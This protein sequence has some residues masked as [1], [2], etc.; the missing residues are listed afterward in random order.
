M[1]K[2]IKASSKIAV[3]II[4]S[5]DSIRLENLLS[6]IHKREACIPF[7]ILGR[8]RISD[9][10]SSQLTSSITAFLDRNLSYQSLLDALHKSKLFYNHH[11]RLRDVDGLRSSDVFPGLVG[12]SD[13]IQEVRRMMG[14]VANTEVSVL[15]TGESGTRKDVVSRNLHKNNKRAEKPF[16]PKNFGAITKE[17]LESELFGH[18][19]GAFTGAN[20]TRVGYFWMTS[21]SNLFFR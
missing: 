19:K 21:S 2:N 11:N 10:L 8:E 15:I 9:S 14:Q 17:L 16:N 13:A 5:L 18:R 6:D 3:A 4:G 7:V 20:E 1:E 12:E